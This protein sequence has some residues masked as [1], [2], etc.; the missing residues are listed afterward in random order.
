MLLMSNCLETL[1]LGYN[2]VEQGS[3]FCLAHGLRLSKSLQ[4]LSLEGN[5]VSNTGM[6]LLMKAKNEN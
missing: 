3:C 4:K 6:S 2:S 1:D 5:P